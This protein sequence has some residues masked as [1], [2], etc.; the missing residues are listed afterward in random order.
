[1]KITFT[2]QYSIGV[3]PTN[4]EVEITLWAPMGEK[5]GTIMIHDKD[6]N[7]TIVRHF[8]PRRMTVHK[9]FSIGGGNSVYTAEQQRNQR[10]SNPNVNYGTTQ[11][12]SSKEVIYELYERELIVPAGTFEK[13]LKTFNVFPEQIE[14]LFE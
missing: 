11:C 9:N 12:Q 10:I 5:S 14:L 4:C 8:D 2:G 13:I 7:K 6:I 3:Y 1:M